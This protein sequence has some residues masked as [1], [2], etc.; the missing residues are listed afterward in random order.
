MAGFSPGKLACQLANRHQL[1]NLRRTGVELRQFPINRAI[2]LMLTV[3][4]R[5]PIA[6]GLDV[7]QHMS[8]FFVVA[9]AR[10]VTPD[11][12]ALF[13]EELN[14]KFGNLLRYDISELLKPSDILTEPMHLIDAKIVF[15]T[16]V[17][18]KIWLS[19]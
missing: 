15:F 7:G 9:E 11:I 16:D 3:S 6:Q 14:K 18:R 13:H 19:A 12:D 10:K 5:I 2:R 1:T 8:M 4:D 17:I